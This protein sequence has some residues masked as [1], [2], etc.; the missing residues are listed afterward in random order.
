MNRG[1]ARV[2]YSIVSSANDSCSRWLA[3]RGRGGGRRLGVVGGVPGEK[4]FSTRENPEERDALTGVERECYLGGSSRSCHQRA[5]RSSR[6]TENELINWHRD[7]PM[8]YSTTPTLVVV[9]I[10]DR[11]H[12][13]RSGSD[14]DRVPL[15]IVGIEVTKI[16]TKS[17]FC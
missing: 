14:V 7:I 15:E 6:K 3:G 13:S 1:G 16:D 12:D 10:Q 9:P 4:R 5:E 8:T 2:Y 17:Q 11:N